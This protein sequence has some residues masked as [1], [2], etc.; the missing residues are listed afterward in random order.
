MLDAPAKG[1]CQ[2]ALGGDCAAGGAAATEHGMA[3]HAVKSEAVGTMSL[4]L[5]TICE[6]DGIVDLLS[7]SADKTARVPLLAVLRGVRFLEPSGEFTSMDLHQATRM[8]GSVDALRISKRGGQNVAV[9]PRHVHLP[10]VAGL[11]QM[12]IMGTTFKSHSQGHSAQAWQDTE[13]LLASLPRLVL[14]TLSVPWFYVHLCL[15]SVFTVR[16]MLPADTAAVGIPERGGRDLDPLHHHTAR[17]A[18]TGGCVR[19]TPLLGLRGSGALHPATALSL[20]PMPRHGMQWRA[21][22]AAL[23][24]SSAVLA[25][26]NEVIHRETHRSQ[27]ASG[28]ALLLAPPLAG[29]LQWGGAKRQREAPQDM[30]HDEWTRLVAEDGLADYQQQ[31]FAAMQQAMGVAH[32]RQGVADLYCGADASVA[33]ARAQAALRT[34]ARRRMLQGDTSQ[35]PMGEVSA[36]PLPATDMASPVGGDAAGDTGEG[37]SEEG[38]S[39]GEG[40]DARM[41][42]SASGVMAVRSQGQGLLVEDLLQGGLTAVE[43]G[44]EDDAEGGAP[45]G[46]NGDD[47]S[48]SITDLPQDPELLP[49]MSWN[50]ENAALLEVC[51]DVPCSAFPVSVQWIAT[52]A[53]LEGFVRAALQ[54][55][56]A[57]PTVTGLALRTVY[58]HATFQPQPVFTERFAGVLETEKTADTLQHLVLGSPSLGWACLSLQQLWGDFYQQHGQGTDIAS[59]S[60]T[61]ARYLPAAREELL[62]AF[63]GG[64]GTEAND[65]RLDVQRSPLQCLARLFL[66]PG[67]LKVTSALSLLAPVLDGDFGLYLAHA[68]DLGVAGA[69]ARQ[70]KEAERTAGELLDAVD[71]VVTL[72]QPACIADHVSVVGCEHPAE[73]PAALAAGAVCL[74]AAASC[75]LSILAHMPHL[76]EH[77]EELSSLYSGWLARLQGQTARSGGT[78]QQLAAAAGRWPDAPQQRYVPGC[79]PQHCSRRHTAPFMALAYAAAQLLCLEPAPGVRRGVELSSTGNG[80]YRADSSVVT[81]P[82]WFQRCSFCRGQGHSHVDCPETQF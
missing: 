76:G 10:S 41:A 22:A 33:T 38:G 20:P 59:F 63:K 60:A 14:D 49:M 66:D 51:D 28:P 5:L 26:R 2:C 1:V 18:K 78:Q 67:V 71:A 77:R 44:G 34:T 74:P 69:L 46:A 37:D 23:T 29:V 24:P 55:M 47:S 81:L 8:V 42:L 79:L 35:G 19:N 11:L 48:R 21:T 12:H 6:H 16:C 13:H 45:E 68:V 31:L 27:H 4:Y 7:S 52:Q 80:G 15:C 64:L 75:V 50:L 56:D 82:A 70:N 3:K 65:T 53:Q 32:Y 54:R 25:L 30:R 9:L 72:Q 62:H 61:L 73:P 40:G 58:I 17:E 57:A 36:P 39:P 43:Q